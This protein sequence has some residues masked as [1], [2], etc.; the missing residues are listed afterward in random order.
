MLRLSRIEIAALSDSQRAQLLVY[1]ARWDALRRASSPPDR[2]RV[3]QSVRIAY[4]AAGL[5]APAEILWEGGPADHSAAWAKRRHTA[6]DN[7]R[8]LVIDAM[9]RKTENAVDR[10]ISLP[11][12]HLR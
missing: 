9:R 6:G 7:V 3:A 10:A 8:A 2:E 1:G 4:T 5:P 12:A 11:V